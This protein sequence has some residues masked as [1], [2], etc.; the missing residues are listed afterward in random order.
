M[1]I[2]TC[3][4][5]CVFLSGFNTLCS[6]CNVVRG[7]FQCTTCGLDSVHKICHKEY[8]PKALKRR[9]E[10]EDLFTLGNGDEYLVVIDESS[11]M[12]NHAAATTEKLL[13]YW[14]KG[15]YTKGI[16]RILSPTNTYLIPF[17]TSGCRF[18]ESQIELGCN[19]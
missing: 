18:Y 9:K 14:K 12:K 6:A 5:G 16:N 8:K 7:C 1:S 15:K 19:I 13:G 11:K 10:L 2:L 3:F 17:T 4:D